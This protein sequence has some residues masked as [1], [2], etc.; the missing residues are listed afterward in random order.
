M[1]NEEDFEILVFEKP[2][3]IRKTLQEEAEE[4]VQKLRNQYLS[5]QTAKKKENSRILGVNDMRH[6]KAAL[7]STIWWKPNEEE[8]KK[9]QKIEDSKKITQRATAYTLELYNTLQEKHKSGK[10]MSKTSLGDP[11][12]LESDLKNLG[13]LVFTAKMFNG[14]YIRKHFSELYDYIRM[15]DNLKKLHTA[16]QDGFPQ[17]QEERFQILSRP[18]ELLT[19]RVK[20]F[21]AENRLSLEQTGMGEVN[22]LDDRAELLE[23]DR[24]TAKDIREWMRLTSEG[25]EKRKAERKLEALSMP[26]VKEAGK[27][28]SRRNLT[29]EEMRGKLE[30]AGKKLSDKQLEKLI[31]EYIRNEEHRKKNQTLLE[32]TLGLIPYSMKEEEEYMDFLAE[33]GPEARRGYK[34]P[35]VKR[36]RESV[37]YFALSSGERIQRLPELTTKIQILSAMLVSDDELNMG[38]EEAARIRKAVL[39]LEALRRLT[40]AEIN[41]H[42]KGGSDERELLECAEEVRRI[43]KRKAK[44][45]RASLV[46]EE[47]L[48][49]KYH[50]MTKLEAT[51]N[52]SDD[53][54][55]EARVKL[56][57][58]GEALRSEAEKL[59]GE[60]YAALKAEMTQISDALVSW[61]DGNQYVV[62]HEVEENRF[63]NLITLINNHGEGAQ[64]PALESLNRQLAALK[65]A[66]LKLANGGLD[67]DQKYIPGHEGDENYRVIEKSFVNERPVDEGNFEKSVS[68]L[69][70]AMH[71]FVMRTWEDRSRDPLFAHEPTVN[72]LRQGKIS[73]CWMVAA[74]TSLIEMDP[75]IIKNCMKDNG[76]GTVTVRLYDQKFINGG[77]CA[78]PVYVTVKK[79]TPRLITGGTILTDGPLWM[80]VLER[81]AAHLGRM[82]ERGHAKG[83]RSLWHGKPTDW[84]FALTGKIGE[85]VGSLNGMNLGIMM[86]GEEMTE[87]GVEK[88]S[89]QEK[90]YND[91][92]TAK[93][94]GVVY[95]YGTK[96][97]ASGGM[98]SGHAYTVLGAEEIDGKKYII[99]RN[100]YANMTLHYDKDGKESMEGTYLSS[101]MNEGCGQFKILVKD[102]L[103]NMS[104]LFR[105]DL[106]ADIKYNPAR[107]DENSVI[108]R[109][110]Q[111][112]N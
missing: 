105:T 58:L 87:G 75:S 56:L 51:N 59:Q 12:Q 17:E 50:R 54:S 60:G 100:P 70:G 27:K 46:P 29:V 36:W 30:E 102:F 55:Y 101:E 111:N 28:D 13:R 37:N 2:Q 5:Q 110:A 65:T 98:N 104:G 19:K 79:E 14:S 41:Y 90:V 69:D 15:Y 49:A 62:G 6:D 92:L 48:D 103:A 64:D 99:L 22:V 25:K 52:S 10:L 89:V 34:Q 63:K 77:S 26:W 83:F 108:H 74:T 53:A 45:S 40:I 16:A 109:P 20:Q 42:T 57:N 88:D 91:I 93:S 67:T 86:G 43:R 18:M 9:N 33:Y 107:P 8:Q 11:E 84:I 73:N 32:K 21:A 23:E 81:A 80:S 47:T 85:A 66:V 82:T 95:S 24:I 39:E 76:D 3:Q 94:R 112:G 38:E 68:F 61:F 106:K 72:D 31:K 35:K 71:N 97:G 1:K 44:S 78:W 96:K 4:G 7:G